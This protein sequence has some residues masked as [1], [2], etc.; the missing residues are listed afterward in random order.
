MQGGHSLVTFPEMPDD[1]KN[2]PWEKIFHVSVKTMWPPNK[3]WLWAYYLNTP[4]IERYTEL[5]KNA[6]AS[7]APSSIL[8]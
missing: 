5:P 6:D 4:K 2:F 1:L 8:W 3:H 7:L